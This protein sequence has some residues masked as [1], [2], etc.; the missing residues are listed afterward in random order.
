MQRPPHN[1]EF[2]LSGAEMA[3]TSEKPFTIRE[4]AE[5]SGLSRMTITRLFENERGVI[6]L[7]RPTEMRKRRYRSIRIPRPVFERVIDR[8]TVK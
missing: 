2:I 6:V 3:A 8:L 5:L 1:S 4:A 7:E